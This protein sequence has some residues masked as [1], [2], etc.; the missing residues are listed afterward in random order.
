MMIV[1]RVPS[2]Q[3]PPAAALLAV[4]LGV[5]VASCAQAVPGHARPAPQHPTAPVAASP[6]SPSATGDGTAELQEIWRSAFPAAFG[7]AWTDIARF[8]PVHPANAAAP[9]PPCVDEA[10][11]LVGQAFYCPAADAIIW[12]A[13]TLVPDLHRRFG[14]AGATI[15]L[16]HEVGHAVQTRLLIDEA[17]SREPR[18]YPAIPHRTASARRS[19]WSFINDTVT[20]AIPRVRIPRNRSPAPSEWR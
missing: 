19:G 1:V 18:R 10:A 2:R 3:R 13:D 7:R 12:D 5:L 8:E 17:Q 4:A 11:D 16:A 6:R 20:D 9:A 14:S 15:A